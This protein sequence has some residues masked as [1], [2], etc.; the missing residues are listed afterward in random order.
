MSMILCNAF[1]HLIFKNMLPSER[2]V[3]FVYPSP[4]QSVNFYITSVLILMLV[5]LPFFSSLYQFIYFSTSPVES[6]HRSLLEH[7]REEF[8]LNDDSGSAYKFL[9]KILCLS[10]PANDSQQSWSLSA[11]C[12]LSV[13]YKISTEPLKGKYQ[14]SLLGLSNKVAVCHSAL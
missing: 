6:G 10:S 14:F 8:F 3:C 13:Q 1:I 7:G 11:K 2:A 5:F 4:C 9:G 12:F